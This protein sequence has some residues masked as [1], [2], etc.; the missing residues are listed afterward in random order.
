MYIIVS[1]V[2]DRDRALAGCSITLDGTFRV[3]GRLAGVR[4][5]PLRRDHEG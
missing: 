4:A 5:V 3:A 1:F 2:I